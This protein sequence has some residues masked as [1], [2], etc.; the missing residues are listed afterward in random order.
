[1]QPVQDLVQPNWD[2]LNLNNI[3]NI[4]GDM[5]GM[6]GAMPDFDFVRCFRCVYAYMR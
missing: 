1:M 3:N 5:Q 4:V 2:D 6:P